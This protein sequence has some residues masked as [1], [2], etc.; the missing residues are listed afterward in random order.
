MTSRSS[1]KTGR[2]EDARLLFEQPYDVPDPRPTREVLAL[3][4][5]FLEI[6]KEKALAPANM[7]SSAREGLPGGIWMYFWDGS[8]YADMEFSNDGRVT[9]CFNLEQSADAEN[10]DLIDR[11]QA[12]SPRRVVEGYAVEPD[13]QGLRSAVRAILK[14]VKRFPAKPV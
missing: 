11:W 3:V 2:A 13:E 6:L 7:V 5:R 1:S 12:R 8:N 14:Y 9:L 4:S 10:D